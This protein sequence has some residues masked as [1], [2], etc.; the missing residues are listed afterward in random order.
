MGLDAQLH[1]RSGYFGSVSNTSLTNWQLS[2][3]SLPLNVHPRRTI[4]AS[5]EGTIATI[6]PQ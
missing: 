4:T 2:K 1:H 6:W 5:R 3:A